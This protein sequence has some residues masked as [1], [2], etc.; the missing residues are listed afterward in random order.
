[1]DF[2]NSH[3]TQQNIFVQRGIEDD[4]F[5]VFAYLLIQLA[6]QQCAECHIFSVCFKEK[7]YSVIIIILID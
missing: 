4:F 6:V 5:I 7:F 2:I 3:F 1:M